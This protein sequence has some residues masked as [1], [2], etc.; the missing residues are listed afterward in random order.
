MYKNILVKYNHL[1]KSLHFVK[2]EKNPPPSSTSTPHSQNHGKKTQKTLPPSSHL[3][4]NTPYTT[5]K[6]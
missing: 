4:A 6:Q 3:E 1:H 2:N 5:E